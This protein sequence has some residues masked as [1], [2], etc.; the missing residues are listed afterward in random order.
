MASMGDTPLEAMPTMTSAL[1]T[2]IRLNC[3]SGSN[4]LASNAKVVR[5]RRAGAGAA[6]RPKV[7]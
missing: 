7:R 4:T 2:T 3:A 5:R 1:R 6:A